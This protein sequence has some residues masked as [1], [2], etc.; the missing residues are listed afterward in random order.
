MTLRASERQPAEGPSTAGDAR[1][2]RRVGDLRWVAEAFVPAGAVAPDP[3]VL[4]RRERKKA[5][6][7]EALVVESQR[8]FATRGYNETTLDD[9]SAAVDITTPTLLRY[10]ESKAQLALAPLIAPLEE[11]E[12]FLRDAERAVATLDAWRLYVRLEAQE[13]TEPTSETTATYVA[14]LRAYRE[15]VD[16]DPA[17]VARLSDVER[18]LQEVLAAAMARDAGVEDDDLHTTLVAALLVAGRRAVWDR[19]LARDRDTDSLVDDQTAVVDYA[20]ESLPRGRARR[21]LAAAG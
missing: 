8:L 21:L 6:T 9:I 13:A 12:R 15:W 11:V 20:V 14:N 3:V 5:R 18:W 16:R 7:R 17:L 2:R 10:F 1:V 4:S 19:W